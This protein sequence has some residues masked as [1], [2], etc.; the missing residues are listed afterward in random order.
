VQVHT[1]PVHSLAFSQDSQVLATGSEDCSVRFWRFSDGVQLPNTLEHSAGVTSVRYSPD[2]R[3]V[4]TG[5]HDG[6]IFLWIASTTS[7][8]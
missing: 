5:T 2:G 7:L 1:R 4:A 6:R 8:G 3:T